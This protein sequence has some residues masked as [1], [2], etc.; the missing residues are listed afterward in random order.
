VTPGANPAVGTNWL[1]FDVAT[2]TL[3]P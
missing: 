3:N 2:F 1:A